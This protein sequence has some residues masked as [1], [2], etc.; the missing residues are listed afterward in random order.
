MSASD[1][2]KESRKKL[3]LT[4]QQM[5]ETLGLK[6]SKIK[7]MET[8]RLKITPDIAL[9]IEQN[10]PTIDAGWLIFGKNT[11]SDNNSTTV[12]LPKLSMTASA[13][14]GSDLE[15]I[16]IFQ[17]GETIHIDK[18]IFK[19]PPKNNLGIIQVDGYSMVPMLLPDSWVIYEE[20]KSYKTD[21]MYI[22][23]W[24]NNLMVKLLQLDLSTGAL[25]IISVNKDYKSYQTSPDD[26]SS[27]YII[28]KVIKVII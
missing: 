12:A 15:G 21:G 24:R 1:R 18:A 25:D 9:S 8:S 2:L 17:T 14:A 26:Q 23:N 6:W 13:G 10:Y 20:T 11:Q 7:D 28:G 22:L 19:T 5:A 4:Q 27:F 16:E 3:G